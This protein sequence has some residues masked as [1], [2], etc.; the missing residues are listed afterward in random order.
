MTVRQEFIF[1]TVDGRPYIEFWDWAKTLP[2]EQQNDLNQA[3][4]RQFK[5]RDE[6]IARG[7]LRISEDQGSYIWKDEF[8]AKRQH[9]PVWDSYFQR[10]RRECGIAEVSKL[11]KE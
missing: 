11:I 7:D 6:A 2:L 1:E 3:Q 5:L 9:D 4:E 10:W 8:A